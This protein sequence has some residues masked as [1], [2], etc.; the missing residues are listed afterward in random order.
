M[1]RQEL[2]VSGGVVAVLLLVSLAPGCGG[3]DAKHG[4]ACDTPG[5]IQRCV[6]P[7]RADGIQTCQDDGQWSSCDCSTPYDQLGAGGGG[8]EAD[9]DGSGGDETGG[10]DQGDSGGTAGTAAGGGGGTDLVGGSGGQAGG[11]GGQ[12]IGAGGASGEGGDT[13][14]GGAAGQGAYGGTAGDVGSGGTAGASSAGTGG[15][16]V[17][18]GTAGGDP[19]VGGSGLGGEPGSGGSG[20]GGEGT[21]GAGTGGEG[22][23]GEGTGGEGTGGAGTGG[24]GTGGDGTGGEGTGGSDDCDVP[25]EPP[26]NLVTPLAEV[27][28]HY[29]QTYNL[30]FS[31]F[32]WDQIMANG[33]YLNCCVRWDSSAT[34]S[35][36]LRDQIHAALQRQMDHWLDWMVEN[37]SGWNC[38]PYTSIP[39]TVVGWAVRD[40]NQLDWT[41]GSVD[42]Y[43]NDIWEDAPQCAQACGRFF[44]QDGD[45]SSCPG[46]EA[47]HYDMSLWLTEGFSGGA[48]GDWGQR[49]DSGYLVSNVETDSIMILLH[50]MGHSFGLDDFYDWQP[51]G[52]NS[53][54][55]YAGSSAVVTEFDGWMLR[56]WWR[57][58]RPRYGL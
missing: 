8:G 35:A 38:W 48:G 28:A 41:D 5:D 56:D 50:E 15:V 14:A 43:E 57:H 9:S 23:G 55:M 6:C 54:I 51:T 25:W 29:E 27:W 30:D 31:N 2:R 16:V 19:G 34:V 7:D 13:A 36:A 32:A 52:V 47:H 58:L 42:I 1:N 21:G 18:G 22:T 53:F 26:G 45:Y 20:T 37:G 49:V 40:R 33:G 24:E 46:G 12:A 3:S 17:T 4:T 39:V 44:H 10:H 11:A